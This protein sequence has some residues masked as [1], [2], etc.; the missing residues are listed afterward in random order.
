VTARPHEA[1][2]APASRAGGHPPL[3]IANPAARS[4]RTRGEIEAIVAALQ[5]RIG[6]VDLAL[7]EHAGQG[8][9]LAARAVAEG[10]PLVVSVGGDG[11][12]NEVVNGLLALGAEE[13]EAAAPHGGVPA[14]QASPVPPQPPLSAASPENLPALGIVSAGTGGDFGR[15]LGL[16]PTREAYLDAIA[17]GHER[18][19]D[20]GRARFVAGGGREVERCFVNV[21]SAGIGGLVDRYTAAMPAVVPGRLAY[22]AATVGAVF[23]CR[24]RRILCRATLADGSAFERVLTTYAVVVANGH[25]FGGGMRVAPAARVDD[26]LLDVILIET[27]TKLTMLRHFLSIYRGEHLTKP[28]VS[29]FAC[30]RVAFLPTEEDRPAARDHFPLDVDGDALGDV[31]LSVEVCPARLRVLA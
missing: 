23:G 17:A 30:T 9:E 11:V 4:G 19:I 7:T 26:G 22:G 18:A 27:P 5:A 20:V 6:A 15:S 8:T 1:G 3:V 31:P 16:A 25:T 13:G 12:L 24:R 29:A 10:R 28:G 2:L 21:L 14:S